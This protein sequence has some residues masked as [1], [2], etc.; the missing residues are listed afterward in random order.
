MLVIQT[1]C[2]ADRLNLPV[3]QPALRRLGAVD[4]EAVIFKGSV[5][6]P[7]VGTAKGL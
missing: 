1:L 6:L 2:L 4:V 3:R 5:D 7:A